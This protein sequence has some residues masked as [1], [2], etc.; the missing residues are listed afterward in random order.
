MFAQLADFGLAKREKKKACMQTC[1]GT[2]PYSAPE[3]LLATRMVPYSNKVDT[4]G[5]G[6]ILFMLLCGYHPF[7]P[8]GQASSS[9]LRKRIVAGDADYSGPAVCC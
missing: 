4:W 1:C 9:V 8:F 5:L 2:L 6:V 7:D 3:M